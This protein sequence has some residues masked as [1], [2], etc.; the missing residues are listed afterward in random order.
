[1]EEGV[2]PRSQQEEGEGDILWLGGAPAN[3]GSCFTHLPDSKYSPECFNREENRSPRSLNS[4]SSYSR[5]LTVQLRHL[6]MP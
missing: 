6:Q 2:K 4:Q 3:R 1:M 5:L